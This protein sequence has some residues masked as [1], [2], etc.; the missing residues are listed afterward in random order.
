MDFLLLKRSL[1]IHISSLLLDRISSIKA[2][3]IHG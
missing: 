3:E 2:L 1:A